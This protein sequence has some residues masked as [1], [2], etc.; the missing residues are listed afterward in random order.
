MAD[1]V[2]V[3]IS[4]AH[5]DRE[6][7]ARLAAEL[8]K[9]NVD[10]FFDQKALRA[11]EE[12]EVQLVDAAKTCRH[13]ICFWSESA[14]KSPWVQQELALFRVAN[15]AG[16]K[17]GPKLLLI[18]LDAQAHT[19]SRIQNIELTG[20]KA[21]YTGP[22][23][24]ALGAADLKALVDR[25]LAV[26]RA[27]DSAIRIPVAVLTLDSAS[28]YF[29]PSEIA[30]I[31]QRLGLSET[32][33]KSRYGNRRLDWKPFTGGD[34]IEFYLNQSRLDIN[35]WLAESPGTQNESIAWDFPDDA[36]FWNDTNNVKQFAGMMEGGKGGLIVIDPVA[37]RHPD[38]SGRLALFARCLRF[39]SVAIVALHPSPATDMDRMFRKWVA[40]N[41]L[42]LLTPYVFPPPMP[43]TSLSAR[44]G[45]GVD[46]I[47]EVHRLLKT[48]IGEYLRRRTTAVAPSAAA[49]R[50]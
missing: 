44:L 17:S 39:E 10:V 43:E 46:D 3:F 50:N 25:I 36:L 41:T 28:A 12:W 29:S 48:S 1:P 33:L 35:A 11:G 13:L 45:I 37:T 22:G 5:Q 42:A 14:Q 21:A 26:V 27:D 31:E 32:D 15:Q 16:N 38:V 4:Y 20:V 6:W 2:D 7:A 23:L 24:G 19:F 40:D 18:P 34:T 49:I 47:T 8:K 9:E 30:L